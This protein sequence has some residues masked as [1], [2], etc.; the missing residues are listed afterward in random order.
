MAVWGHCAT[1]GRLSRIL[2]RDW[3]PSEDGVKR[4]QRWYPESHPV[5]GDDTGGRACPGEKVAL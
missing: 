4:N 5:P 2:P 1:C 3:H